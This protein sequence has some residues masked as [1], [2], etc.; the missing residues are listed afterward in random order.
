MINPA[1][2]VILKHM[3][4]N[5]EKIAAEIA[6]IQK[7]A[8]ENKEIDANALIANVMARYQNNSGQMPAGQKMRA[9]LVSLLL[10]PFGMY[11]VVKFL[12]QDDEAAK[13]VAWICLAITV[14][15]VLATWWMAQTIFSSLGG[16]L[17][18]VSPSQLQE[19]VQ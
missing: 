4:S 12:M 5:E 2:N 9:Y 3:P 8:R 10:P 1:G 18:S 17:Q 19:L 6:E 13:R 15:S 14:G 16:Q 7:L 11:Y